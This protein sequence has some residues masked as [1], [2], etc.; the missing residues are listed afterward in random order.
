MDNNVR[1]FVSMQNKYDFP[2]IQKILFLR[3]YN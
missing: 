1:L 2:K 3:M